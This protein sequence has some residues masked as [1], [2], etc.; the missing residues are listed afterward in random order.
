MP[1]QF[2]NCCITFY[3]RPNR[4]ACEHD[5]IQYMIY[6]REKCPKT[7]NIH[8]QAYCEFK[9]RKTMNV[10]KKHFMDNT[11]HLEERKGTQK[12][13]IDYCQKHDSRD[14]GANPRVFGE[15]R[16]Q[17]HRTDIEELHDYI[18][19][20]HT[21]GEIHQQFKGTAL[22]FA[23]NIRETRQAM[24]GELDEL[25]RSILRHRALRRMVH[26]DES[27]ANLHNETVEEY[28]IGYMAQ[29]NAQRES[30]Y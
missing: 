25:D 18:A 2:R 20:G 1:K 27:L 9:N 22:R 4:E 28:L 21:L 11:I 29:L 13:A 30:A 12:Q 5:D 15:P 19:E 17:G 8:W 10:I 6:Q 24:H 3:T 7:G 23:R 16:V 14:E 26:M